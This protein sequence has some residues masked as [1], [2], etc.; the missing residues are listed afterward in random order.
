MAVKGVVGELQELF[1]IKSVYS[2]QK[3]GKDGCCRSSQLGL[4]GP[5]MPAP[6]SAPG[7]SKEGMG[8]AGP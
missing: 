5:G 7:S 2:S 4:C 8:R 6:F 3:H 1:V